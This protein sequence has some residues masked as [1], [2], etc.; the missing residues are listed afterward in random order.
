MAKKKKV[1]ARAAGK[2]ASA[3]KKVSHLPDGYKGLTPGLVVRNAAEAIAFYQKAFGAK[4]V[5]R[6]DMPDGKIGHSELRVEGAPYMVVDENPAW[7]NQSPASLNGTP[8]TFWVYT[9]DADAFFYRAVQAG[10]QVRMAM[11]D[12]FWGDRMG[13][14][15]DPY[16]HFWAI[17]T[18]KEDL[19][20]EEI[21]RRGAEFMAKAAGS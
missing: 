16:G 4:L 15:A 21:D 11:A 14:I 3:K 18:H 7:G 12:Q 20:K 6:F 17:A 19:S 1:K 2:K 13:M 8:V 5:S 9:K 10:A